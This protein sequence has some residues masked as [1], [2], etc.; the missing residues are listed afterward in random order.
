M[1]Q[2]PQLKSQRFDL[3]PI[4]N[5]TIDNAHLIEMM[6]DSQIQRYINGQPFSDSEAL[7]GLERFHRKTNDQGLGFWLIYDSFNDCVGMCLLKPMPTREDTGHIETGYWIKPTYWGKRIAAEVAGR[8]IK[9]AFNDLDLQQVTA[10]VDPDNIASKKSLLRAGLS[11]RGELI[12][13]DKELP[14]YMITKDEY[15]QNSLHQPKSHGSELHRSKES[16]EY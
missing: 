9:Y 12:A 2:N 14:F 11:H 7:Q 16:F 4:E 5:T 15:L 13:Y 10:V 8:L 6:Q 1:K 3:R